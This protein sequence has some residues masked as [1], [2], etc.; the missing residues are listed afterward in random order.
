MMTIGTRILT[1][2]TEDGPRPVAIRMLQPRAWEGLYRCDYEIHWPDGTA[3]SFAAGNDELHAI[4]LAMQKIAQDLYMSRA[5]AERRL[6]W[7]KPWV[8]YGFPMPANG[9]ELLIG[10][11]K[12]FY[13]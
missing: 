8:G 2:L 10:D 5:H 9:R 13:G 6:S 1:L 12:R 7:I 4:M 11:D 3:K